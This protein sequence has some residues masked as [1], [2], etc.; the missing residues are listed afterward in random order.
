MHSLKRYQDISLRGLL[1]AWLWNSEIFINSLQLPIKSI[2]CGQSVRD[3]TALQLLLE[4]F[5]SLNLT[6]K[7]TFPRITGL[8][9]L[10][11]SV[12]IADCLNTPVT[13]VLYYTMKQRSQR[14]R[15]LVPSLLLKGMLLV[16]VVMV[17]VVDVDV[18]VKV[19]VEVTIPIP[20]T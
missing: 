11:H 17:V 5:Y 13:K 20:N 2:R 12:T 10:L 3:R 16:L 1:S 6:N 14:R 9:P 15:R 8:M 4:V 7:W 19:A 18:V